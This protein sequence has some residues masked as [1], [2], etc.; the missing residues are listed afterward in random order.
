MTP[1]QHCG[2]PMTATYC[3][4]CGM[5]TDTCPTVSYSAIA[6][7]A[8]HTILNTLNEHDQSKGNA[9][10]KRDDDEDIDHMIAHLAA[11]KTGDRSEDHIGHTMTRGALIKAR[12]AKLGL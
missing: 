10:M 8:K 6:R 3:L 9:W 4:D 2:K 5:Q 12:R 7:I 11:Y 1:C